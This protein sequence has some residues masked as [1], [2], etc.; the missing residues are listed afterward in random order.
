MIAGGGRM[1]SSEVEARWQCEI[2]AVMTGLKEWR[3]QHPRASLREIEQALDEKLSRVRARML[4]DIA[5]SSRAAR[6]GERNEADQ[7][8]RSAD[9][10]SAAERPRCP[11]CGGPLES[12][13]EQ[14]RTLITNHNQEI[15]LTRSYGYCPACEAGLFPPR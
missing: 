1:W 12:R 6:L 14:A 3:L 15:R 8:S 2:D 9:G 11:K 13:G 10:K 4:E 5:L 7:A